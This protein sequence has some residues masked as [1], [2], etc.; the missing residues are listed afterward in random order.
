MCLQCRLISSALFRGLAYSDACAGVCV[1]GGEGWGQMRIQMVL[2]VAE[3]QQTLAIAEH[4]VLDESDF[5]LAVV[6]R[7]SIDLQAGRH[8][9][10]ERVV[11]SPKPDSDMR[12]A[13]VVLPS[14]DGDVR[15]TEVVTVVTMA[16][17]LRDEV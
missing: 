1:R 14:P 4:C 7:E 5:E 16:V 15:I 13:D 2:V 8:A 3:D 10:R 12:I 17:R 9:V 6:V 11:L